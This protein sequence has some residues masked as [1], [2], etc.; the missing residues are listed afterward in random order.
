MGVGGESENIHQSGKTEGATE[1]VFEWLLSLL[2]LMDSPEL[3]LAKQDISRLC[4]GGNQEQ[5][6]TCKNQL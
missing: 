3:N 1:K 6:E 2:L 5:T 4:K